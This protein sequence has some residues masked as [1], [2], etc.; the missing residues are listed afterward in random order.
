[1]Q[2]G[3]HYKL[4]RPVQFKGCNIRLNAGTS[5]LVTKFNSRFVYCE[6]NGLPGVELRLSVKDFKQEA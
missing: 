1:M 2:E 6:W 4:T 5:V 3:R